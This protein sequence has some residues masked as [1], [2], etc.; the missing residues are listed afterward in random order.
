MKKELSTILKGLITLLSFVFLNPAI[1][2]REKGESLITQDQINKIAELVKP[3]KE[4]LEKQLS[5]DETYQAYVK[6]IT[7]LNSTKSFEEKSS[8]TKKINEKYSEY[9]KKVWASANVD[10]RAYQSNIRRVFPD[11]LSKLITFEPFLV[12]T[13]S[14]STATATPPPADPPPPDKCLDICTIAAG[15]ITGVSGLIAGGG[16]S[17]GNCFLR[18][19]AWSAVFGGNNSIFGF[20]RNNIT[21]PGTLPNDSRKLRVKKSWELTQEATTFAVFGGGYAETRARTFKSSEYMLV[22]SPVFF[23]S[24]AITKKTMSEEY[25]LEKKDVAFSIFKNMANTF[26][27]FVSGNWCF[28]ECASIKWTICEEK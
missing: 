16:G 5:E 28:S 18:T 25:V 23:G 26:S 13:L 22:Y 11:D 7:E 1:A 10:E 20:L 21:I 4:Q 2:Q 3:I 6:D 19:N 24:H 27:A 17:Y 15:E 14:V 8:M 12:F 9:F